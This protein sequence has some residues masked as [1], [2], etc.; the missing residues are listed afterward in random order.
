MS[1]LLQLFAQTPAGP[2]LL[3]PKYIP[4]AGSKDETAIFN[5]VLGIVYFTAG[6]VA[7][8]ALI[9][10]GFLYATSAGDPGRAKIA[11]NAILYAV[12]G[13]IAVLVAFMI[14]TYIR[15]TVG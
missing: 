4:N 6:I 11:K 7:V 14:T 10:A 3:N 2:K 13:L 1:K 8:I 12:I 9:I 5:D 15:G